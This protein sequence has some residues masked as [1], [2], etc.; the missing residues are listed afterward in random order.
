MLVVCMIES[1]GWSVAVFFHQNNHWIYNI[2]LPIEVLFMIWLFRKI[3]QP[4]VETTLWVIL[5]TVAFVILYGRDGLEHGFREYADFTDTIMAIV[6]VLASCMYYYLLL[7][8]E[9]HVELYQ[10]PPFWLVT[11]MFLFYFGSTAVNVF[12]DELMEVNIMKGISLRYI[13]FTVLNAILYGCWIF[14]FRC[15][16]RQTIS[17]SP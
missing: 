8:D 10:H 12:F 17:S 6:F 1:A 3:F 4:Y 14:A 15:R 2:E 11:G 5:S 9:R 16:Y 7:K 13:I